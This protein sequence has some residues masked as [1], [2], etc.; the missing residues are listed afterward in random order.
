MKIMAIGAACLVV[1][2][3]L[4]AGA[5]LTV[6]ADDAAAPTTRRGGE[7][8]I[9]EKEADRGGHILVFL[10]EGVSDG[11]RQ[12]VEAALDARQEVEAYEYWN[13]EA[14]RAEARRL[15][16]DDPEMLAKIDEGV[17]I[18]E[19]YRLLLRDPSRPNAMVVSSHLEG[20]PGVLQVVISDSVPGLGE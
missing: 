11:E 19:S 6:G 5:V 8:V 2:L 3:A 13:A 4:G 12:G 20:L 1:G 9:D 18:P 10:V 15:F 17:H 16:R 7:Y 14:S